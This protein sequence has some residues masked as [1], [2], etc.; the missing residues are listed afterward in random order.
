MDVAEERA[1]S[2]D[3]LGAI[4]DIYREDDEEKSGFRGY[5]TFARVRERS[6]D[7]IRRIITDPE[8]TFLP[9]IEKCPEV[10]KHAKLL[11][12]KVRAAATAACKSAFS[13]GRTS[14]AVQVQALQK[15]DI[16]VAMRPNCTDPSANDGKHFN[17]EGRNA[18]T[19][20]LRSTILEGIVLAS[21][22]LAQV[23][24]EFRRLLFKS[25]RGH[26]QNAATPLIDAEIRAAWEAEAK[27]DKEIAAM[28]R[29]PSEQNPRGGR[30]RSGRTGSRRSRRA[31]RPQGA[32]AGAEAKAPQR[33]AA[34]GFGARARSSSSRPRG[35]QGQ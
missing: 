33:P 12:D 3:P 13:R 18:S 4:F 6:K 22:N 17:N 9:C 31:P 15:F 20:A 1:P 14:L 10:G 28:Q 29:R 16:A 25:A 19:I 30:R 5:E 7:D 32:N 35:R 34:S 26:T 2:P 21:D 27:E 23:K 8:F 24:N 11:P